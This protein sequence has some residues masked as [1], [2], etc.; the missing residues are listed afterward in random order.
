VPYIALKPAR[1]R[2]TVP[3]C[4][5]RFGQT[6]WCVRGRHAA[7]FALLALAFISGASG[8]NA[9]VSATA[10]PRVDSPGL[11]QIRFDHWSPEDERGFGEFLTAIGDSD[12]RTVD[13]C[14]HGP[15]NPFRASD[16]EGIYFRSDCADLPYVLRF[17][18]AWKRG[19]PFSYVSAVEPRGHTND[20]RYTPRGNSV[21]ART[22]L[23]SGEVSGYAALDTMRDAVSSATYRIHP[24]LEQPLPQDFYSPAITAQAI[25]PGT[26]IY[27]PN[28]HLANVYRVD[29]DGRIHYLDAHP[30][31][32]L[33]R[34]FYDLRF[35]RASPGMGSG[36]K[37]WR[38]QT[39]VGYSRA[40]D[41][42]LIGG[43]VVMPANSQIADYS[44]EQYFGNGPR[45]D[46]DSDWNDG[47]FTLNKEVLDYYDYV[48]AKLAGG[49]LQFDPVKEVR[50]MVDSNC[51]DLHYR[52]D[53]VN[54]AIE[55]GQMNLPQPDRLPQNIYGSD[56]DWE[57]YSSPSR[58]ARLK[59]AFKELR[60][61]VQRFVAMYQAGDPKLVYAGQNL[62]ADL[63][64]TY[65]RQA[66]A[67][68]IVYT[69]TDRTQ[70]VLTYEEARRR[71]FAM[72]F[73]PHHCIELRW[74]AS[75][76]REQSSCPDN[77]KK[78]AWYAA[79]Q[80]LRN[81]L[82]R[83][84]DASMDFDLAQLRERAPGSGVDSAPDIDARAYLWAMRGA[85]RGTKPKP[86]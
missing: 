14:L 12:C 63:I 75:D 86:K 34:G 78:R 25:R 52:A 57:I 59:T 66:R 11:Y 17:Y 32:S 28:G 79:E 18:Y 35:V 26:V 61:T 45:P 22:T 29:P 74:G 15:G 60:D 44:D 16:P 84:Y 13:R 38:P 77:S 54:L 62:V 73:D 53:A 69:R 9:P 43:Q 40:P 27:D 23:Q 70:I 72:S 19:L 37:N 80:R 51:A 55:A 24:D 82:E 49:K 30:D 3:N 56:G 71:L 7:I 20:I 33:T 76:A 4:S 83:T 85:V 39:L 2:L 67:C 50:D 6:G 8:A 36:F 1:P 48:R 10:T 64:A 68:Q 58:D 81:Q 47:T 31:N 42:V 5:L 65:D 46:D 41:G 21:A